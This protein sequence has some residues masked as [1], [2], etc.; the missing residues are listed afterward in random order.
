MGFE[1]ECFC[2]SAVLWNSLE[3]IEGNTPIG[4]W[5]VFL[6]LKKVRGCYINHPA[7]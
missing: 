2:N 5:L 4:A 6:A 3:Q 7:A 1:S